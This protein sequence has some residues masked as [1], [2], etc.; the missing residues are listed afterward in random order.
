MD[1]VTGSYTIMVRVEARG[2]LPQ[3]RHLDNAAIYIIKVNG[4]HP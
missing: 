1:A 4:A 3:H 2:V